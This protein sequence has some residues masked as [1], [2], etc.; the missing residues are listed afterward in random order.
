MI[1]AEA[2]DD[3]AFA[4]LTDESFLRLVCISD[5]DAESHTWFARVTSIT[6]APNA[7]ATVALALSDGGSSSESLFK[8]GEWARAKAV[9]FRDERLENLAQ[10][11]FIRALKLK[12]LSLA[13]TDFEGYFWLADEA[14]RRLDRPALREYYVR[15]GVEATV[16]ARGKDNPEAYYEA[17]RKAEEMLP[18]ADLPG[19]LLAK[20]FNME[21]GREADAPDTD[22][23]ALA[24]K[25]RQIL[26][27]SHVSRKFLTMAI[28]VERSKLPPGDYT[29]VYGLAR[30]VREIHP[31]YPDYRRMVWDAVALEKA[32]LD[33]QDSQAWYRLGNR[34]TYFLDDA[35]QAAVCFKAAVR[36]DPANAE[37][38]EKLRE[39][40]YV[41][42]RERWWLAQELAGSDIFKRA[43]Q[44]EDLSVAGEVSIGMNR[45]QVIR[46]KGL[47]NAM[48][49]SAGGWGVTTQWVYY[50]EGRMLYVDMIADTVV[51]KG[52]IASEKGS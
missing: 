33:P 32:G 27:E 41:Y 7:R 20:G 43:Q 38:S 40:G 50:T 49:T 36:L 23:Y 1:A 42:Y 10:A 22:Y 4:D 6:P 8:M 34:I 35:Y 14:A 17:A 3:V 26:G 19:I 30:K 45:D 52:E 9:E 31:A 39:L 11:A 25:A 16:R 12:D 2:E 28:D 48:N 51:S 18:G 21:W 47:P 29:A 46:A 5:Y 44:L 13:P 37:A 24:D 15:E